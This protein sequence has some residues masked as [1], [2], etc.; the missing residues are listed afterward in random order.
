MFDTKA[1]AKTHLEHMLKHPVENE[2]VRLLEG[3]VEWSE[4]PTE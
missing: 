1:S 3:H 2:E 4:V